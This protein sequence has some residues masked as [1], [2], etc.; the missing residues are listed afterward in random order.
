MS[1]PAADALE[2]L[3]PDAPDA[4]RARAR[5]LVT[6][7]RLFADDSRRTDASPVALRLPRAEDA[8]ERAGDATLRAALEELAARHLAAALGPDSFSDCLRAPAAESCAGAWG[9]AL[10][11]GIEPAAP[12]EA[13]A[14]V[15]AR[16]V[17]G[18]RPLL[19]AAEHELWLARLA[20][21]NEGPAAAEPRFEDLL[22]SQRAAGAR[23]GELARRALAG[24][25]TCRLDRGA[26]AR[27]ADALA[28]DAEAVAADSELA[29]LDVWTRLLAGDSEEALA[30]ALVLGAH[31]GRLPRP[32]V[33]L[34]DERP[35]W[36]GALSGRADAPAP[37]EDTARGLLEAPRS[38]A[39][40]GATVLCAFAF[41]PGEDAALV[42][43]DVAPALDRVQPWA[44]ERELAAVGS[45]EPEH[46][47]LVTMRPVVLHREGT[48]ALDGAL[49]PD[50]RALAVVPVPDAE[51]EGI[52]W[53]RLELAHHLVPSRARL[54]RAARA[55]SLQLAQRA[56]AVAIAAAPAPDETCTRALLAAWVTA[57]GLGTATR[58]WSAFAPARGDLALLAEGGV[59]LDRAGG[60]RSLA[61]ALATGGAVRWS[62][63][64]P[65]LAVALEARS[66]LA[67]PVHCAGT[68][69]CVL[70]FESTRRGDF[71]DAGGARWRGTLARLGPRVVAARFRDWHRERTGRDAVLDPEEGAFGRATRDFLA[72]ARATAPVALTGPSGSGRETAARFLHAAGDARDQ[73]F[74]VVHA[75][76]DERELNRALAQAAPGG[77]VLRDVDRWQRALQRALSERLGVERR[78]I[79]CGV[80]GA[81]LFVLA[82]RG[83]DEAVASGTLLPELGERLARLELAVPPLADR[84]AEIPALARL[85]AARAAREERLAPIELGDEALA[86]LWR[87]PWDGQV[88]A[89]EHFV[90]KLALLHPGEE[91][92]AERVRALARRFDQPWTTRIPS[93]H[94]RALDVAAAL[95]VTRTGRGTPNKTRAAAWLGWDP[96][97]LLTKMRALKMDP[98]RVPEPV[99]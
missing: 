72:A 8:L 45:G 29:R 5:R 9:T 87:Q 38:R 31:P 6:F 98:G 93:R 10:D 89:L 84:R 73:P 82:T 70:V 88:R 21:A 24:L 78:G 77:L 42:H 94:P 86:E 36:L 34:R 7:L 71:E 91:V 3:L 52:G 61:R 75:A 79:G 14:E 30:G 68:V 33:E 97:T 40:F 64:D 80:G 95:R 11:A 2:R 49:D 22:A 55:W 50:A 32:L 74:A 99:R 57:S 15:A 76:Q 12:G 62:D 16:L 39:A 1:V 48:R 66:G 41:R 35:E 25:V 81:R 85:F 96:Q 46:Q 17:A 69:A 4:L 20:H 92:G 54:V 19:S 60:G 65:R 23:A 37:R 58:R 67:L 83:L 43:A 28:T 59:D 63:P 44:R 26:V 56:P 51:G 53:L 13:P 27:A 90:F 18:L 47:A